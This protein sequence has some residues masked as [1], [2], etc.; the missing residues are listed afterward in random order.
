MY[1]GIA[2][3]RR[4]RLP[5]AGIKVAFLTF[6]FLIRICR[7]DPPPLFSEREFTCASF[8]E[9]VNHFISLGEDN[10]VK[11]LRRLALRPGEDFIASH[12]EFSVNERIGWVCRVLFQPNDGKP[13]R[14]PLY[15]GLN[16]PENSMPLKSWPLYPVAFSGGTYFV[17]SQGYMLLGVAEDPKDYIDYCRTTGHFRKTPIPVPTRMDALRDATALKESEPWR[18]IKWKDRGEEWN[19]SIN[20]E[21]VW[22][23][24][25]NQAESIH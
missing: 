12:G 10:A 20:E 2:K 11:E 3:K 4:R 17:L 18:V 22:S 15:G 9:A 13:L 25:Q 24:I 5:L 7:S 6:F 19:Y 23:F 21:R 1:L 8:A 16:L 14:P